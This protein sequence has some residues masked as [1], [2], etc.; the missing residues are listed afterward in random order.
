MVTVDCIAELSAEI[1][2][3]IN[4]NP[5]FITQPMIINGLEIILPRNREEIIKVPAIIRSTPKTLKSIK[6]DKDI[7][8]LDT[9]YAS[10]VLKINCIPYIIEYIERK[11]GRSVNLNLL[12]PLRSNIISFL[13]LLSFNTIPP[14]FKIYK[15]LF[16]KK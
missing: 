13:L 9:L 8:K 14:F 5:K 7:Y 11:P 12:S 10:R 6:L 16:D 15:R 4:H 3:Y 1:K 2:T